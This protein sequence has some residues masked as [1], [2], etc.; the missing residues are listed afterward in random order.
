MDKKLDF[1]ELLRT[2]SAKDKALILME[3][4]NKLEYINSNILDESERLLN[5]DEV[6]VLLYSFETNKDIKIYNE[7]RKKFE[8]YVDGSL[9]A[10]TSFRE[11]EAT[12]WKYVYWEVKNKT[13]AVKY[14]EDLLIHLATSVN[15]I[16]ALSE[17]AKKELKFKPVQKEQFE[18][19]WRT[20]L[21]MIK[22]ISKNENI[23]DIK[24]PKPDKT[25]V[26]QIINNRL[27]YAIKIKRDNE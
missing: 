20:Y 3:H 11:M 19:L 17:Y 13:T 16:E 14:R 21:D 25:E 5:E 12:F 15:M 23:K 4:F 8:T 1:N 7:V 24:I 10:Y 2:T 6:K 18:S 9:Y 26:K 27:S 22:K